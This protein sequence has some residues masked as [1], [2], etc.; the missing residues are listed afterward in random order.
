MV[1]VLVAL[2]FAVIFSITGYAWWLAARRRQQV[3]KVR[4]Y[5]LY[6]ASTIV[7]ASFGLALYALSSDTRP[8]YFLAL[9]M[10][11][12]YWAF[13]AVSAARGRTLR[14]ADEDSPRPAR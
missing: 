4:T 8:L 10:A 9:I 12:A 1:T 3:P 13:D 14:A 2:A 5:R 7:A 6:L 11:G